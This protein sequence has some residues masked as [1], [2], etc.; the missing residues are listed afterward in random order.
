MTLSSSS[1][2]GDVLR[3]SWR[4][5]YFTLT[6]EHHH[7][8]SHHKVCTVIISTVQMRILRHREVKGHSQGHTARKWQSWDPRPCLGRATLFLGRCHYTVFS[9][10]AH[11]L[12]FWSTHPLPPVTFLSG[13]CHLQL[14][15]P[16]DLVRDLREG[17]EPPGGEPG[18]SSPYVH[19]TLSALHSGISCL[20]N[21]DIL[22]VYFIL[23]KNFKNVIFK[24]RCNLEHKTEGCSLMH[25]YIV[26]LHIITTDVGI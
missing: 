4:L 15:S 26:Y 3:A 6:K 20:E 10:Q 24:L 18:P 12:Y 8:Q 9:P 19:S 7:H 23:F 17:R 13:Q 25:V 14:V 21:T 5:T 1:V 22:V 16:E 2:S 11:A